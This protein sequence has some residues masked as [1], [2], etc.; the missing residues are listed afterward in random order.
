MENIKYNYSITNI[1]TEVGITLSGRRTSIQIYES[2]KEELVKIRGYLETKNG[3][4]R[5]L[6]EVIL[7]LIK[8]WKEVHKMNN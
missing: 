8:C 3:K 6:E 7:E 5:S 1:D 4:S 2:T